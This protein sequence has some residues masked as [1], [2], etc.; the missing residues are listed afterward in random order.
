[1]TYKLLKSLIVI[2]L[3]ALSS[4]ANAALIRYDFTDSSGTAW[5]M[6]ASVELDSSNLIAGPN[7][8]PSF[9]SWAMSWT[10]GTTTFTSD[11]TDSVLHPASFFIVDPGFVRGT[12]ANS[13]DHEAEIQTLQAKIGELVV[14]R[15]FLARAFDR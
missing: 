4:M 10:D 5:A 11:N 6:T 3:F 9:T 12:P 8:I 14:E 7:L 1:M 13:A 15:D 2:S